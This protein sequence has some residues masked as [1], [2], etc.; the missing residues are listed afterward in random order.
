[1]GVE[2]QLD[3]DFD[4]KTRMGEIKEELNELNKEAEDLAKKIQYNLEELGL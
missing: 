4:Y 1:M 2:D 3:H